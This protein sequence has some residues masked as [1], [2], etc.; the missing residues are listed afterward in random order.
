MAAPT[1]LR[2]NRNRVM[3]PP[4]SPACYLG[5]NV[6]DFNL[7]FAENWCELRAVV[8]WRP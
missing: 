3:V 5:L 1:R 7:P 2:N 6:L 4:T 8:L